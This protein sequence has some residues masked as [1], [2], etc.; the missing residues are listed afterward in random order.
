[1][2]IG[3]GDYRYEWIDEWAKVPDTESHRTNGRTHGV[4]AS[5]DGS[6]YVFTQGN[7]GVLV[8]DADGKMISSWGDR[9][10]GAHGMTLVE[11][12]GIEYLWLA[13]EKSKEVVKTTL[14]GETVMNLPMPEHDAYA[15]GGPYIPTWVAVHEERHGGNGDIW[16]ADGYGMS[17]IHRH[18]KAGEYLGSVS[19]EK[20]VG[21]FAC[22][23]GIAFDY[24]SGNPELWVADRGNERVQVLDPEGNLI[25]QVGA[26]TLHSPCMFDFYEN[27][28][29]CP[30][31]LARVDLLD[32]YDR[33]VAM[34]GD[35]G[36]I[37]SGT[38]GWPNHDKQGELIQPG[39]F[40]S[41]HG[42]CFG[43][44]GDIYIVEWIIGGRIT[45][46]KKLS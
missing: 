40:N 7:P 16:I 28:C 39:K 9:F 23:H 37:L 45:K 5:K 19:G 30:E 14:T 38:P 35:N 1:M 32:E 15:D 18:N 25:R 13:D 2:E 22:P 42:G 24:R 11:E 17:L 12:D 8:F 34:L 4:V 20:A 6:I 46:L 31:L 29:L 43:P 26:K 27:L 36:N 33:V 3:I 41:P 21:R 10:A 44:N